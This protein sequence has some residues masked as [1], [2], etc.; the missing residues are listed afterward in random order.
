MERL[1][2]LGMKVGQSQEGLVEFDESALVV[3]AVR[4]EAALHDQ[5]GD[6]DSHLSFGGD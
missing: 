5:V 2:S 1:R 4:Q 6:G 3:G